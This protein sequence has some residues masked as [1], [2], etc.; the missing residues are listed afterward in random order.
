MKYFTSLCLAALFTLQATA[1]EVY[2]W[3]Q[4][5]KVVFQYKE[6][7]TM[8]KVSNGIVE[9]DQLP[10]LSSLINQYDIQSVEQLHPGIED[11]K[12]V[13][14]YEIV[15]TDIEKVD[16]LAK[17]V[18]Q[19][20]DI[21]YAEKKELHENFLTPNDQYFTNSFNN[22]QWALY[23]IDAQLAWDI[24]TG[25]SNVV[26]AVTDNAINTSHPDLVNKMVA[27]WDAAENDN[28][29]N[30][31]GGNDGFHG[32]HVSGIVGAETDNNIGIASIGF[33]VSINDNDGDTDAQQ[34]IASASPVPT[35]QAA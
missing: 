22:G 8:P 16:E 27:G 3:Y 30:P 23:Q 11:S 29:P 17:A 15:F 24:S 13:R 33:N 10:F 5:G 18:S 14:T 26:V 9:L 35:M 32:S 1:Q 21:L 25:S 20:P 34:T 7:A 2:R 31:C 4:D 28:D 6:S 12:L 19:S